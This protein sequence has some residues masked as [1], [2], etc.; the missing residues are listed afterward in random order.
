MQNRPVIRLVSSMATRDMLAELIAQYQAA[1]SCMVIA[2]A[3]GGVDVA[4]RVQAGEA[5]DLVVLAAN[6]IDQLISDGKLLAGS[7]VDLAKS[8]V[9]IV[10][11]AGAPLPDIT[12]EEAV[13]RAVMAASTISHS[14][15]PSGVYLR[16]LFERWGILDTLEP[17]IVQAPPGVP[18][19]SL[20]AKGV[21][22]LGFQ[23]LSELI[24]LPGVTV[25][26]LMPAAIQL[27]TIFSAG[28]SATSRQPEVAA[29]LCAF[30]A[31]PAAALAK[32]KQGMEPA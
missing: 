12:T 28:I 5:F 11:P 18:V 26:G 4:K 10:V 1:T 32:R 27:I 23:Q 25:V 7:R 24:N 16:K 13:K 9:A 2:E 19:G 31:A 14:T 21:V 29:A 15:G 17:R 22:A 8:G 20:V 6:A 3:G 30:M